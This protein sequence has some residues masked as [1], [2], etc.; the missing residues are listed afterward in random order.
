MSQKC[1]D[2]FCRW[3]IGL[4][5]AAL[6]FL[7]AMALGKITGCITGIGFLTKRLRNKLRNRKH[8]RKLKFTATDAAR[9]TAC[10]SVKFCKQL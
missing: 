10:I 9:D 6:I 8:N 5:L 7:H 1:V 4:I 2:N 3:K